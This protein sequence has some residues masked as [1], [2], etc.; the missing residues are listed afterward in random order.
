MESENKLLLDR[1]KNKR[2]VEAHFFAQKSLLK[3]LVNYGSWLIPRAF[4]S[5]AK[6][7]EDAIIIG[8]LLKQV[9]T[10]VDAVQVL[11]SEGVVT[12]ALLQSRSALEA[13]L[14]IDWILLNATSK[15]ANYYYVSCLRNDRA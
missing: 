9:V 10:M 7:L 2:D 15:K 14:Y 11:I 13:S 3:E 12:P 5:S 8:V 1:E 6:K 4:D